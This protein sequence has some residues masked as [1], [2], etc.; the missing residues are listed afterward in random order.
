VR[1]DQPRTDTLSAKMATK[2]ADAILFRVWQ[3]QAMIDEGRT[4]N[5]IHVS[6][7]GEEVGAATIDKG[8]FNVYSVSLAG[9]ESLKNKGVV[10]LYGEPFTYGYIELDYVSVVR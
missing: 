5:T 8:N 7:D 10:S 4:L 6:V 3:P 2:K 9:A 1:L